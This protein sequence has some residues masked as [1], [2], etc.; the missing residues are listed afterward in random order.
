[1]PKI[2]PYEPG[3]I[4]TS[5]QTG[6]GIIINLLILDIN[7]PNMNQY[8]VYFY[9]T[10]TYDYPIVCFFDLV[11]KATPE[12]RAEANYLQQQAIGWFGAKSRYNF[13][14]IVMD[15]MENMGTV[16]ILDN[17]H[18][19]MK[20]NHMYYHVYITATGMFDYRWY[21]KKINNIAVKSNDE[22]RKQ[23]RQL[24]RDNEFIPSFS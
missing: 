21:R 3:D 12:T 5:E 17:G 2:F 9:D 23:A 18:R 15:P 22:T 11:Q 13:G 4:I 7:D 24:L 16:L 14:D 6:N 19:N 10:K 20:N 8:R 1:M